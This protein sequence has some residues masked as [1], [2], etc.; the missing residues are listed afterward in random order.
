MFSADGRYGIVFNGEIYN[1]LEL[2]KRLITEGI[3]FKSDS[4]TEVLVNA[5]SSWGIE[6]TLKKS[7]GMFAFAVWDKKD[8]RLYL[9]RDRFGEKP[10]YYGQLGD[11]F[12]FVSELKAISVNYKANLVIDRDA[13][14]TYMRYGYVPTPY[15]IY[16]NIFKL[17]SGTYLVV[18]A[19]LEIQKKSYWSSIEAARQGF[20]NPL[21]IS[22]Q[23][24]SSQLEIKLKEDVIINS[25]PKKQPSELKK[26]IKELKQQIIFTP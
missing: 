16:K 10:L 5:I 23:E 19:N 8:R 9:A 22:F 14:A 18:D 24:A 1:Y 6:E 25:S 12:V 17:E 11:D 3:V 21:K 2:K 20:V 26:P 7:V 13:L 4:D 15:S